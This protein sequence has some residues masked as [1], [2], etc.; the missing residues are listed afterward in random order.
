MKRII[1]LLMV[2]LILASCQIFPESRNNAIG[3][4]AIELSIDDATP[5][6]ISV[7]YENGEG[8]SSTA[9]F[10]L[11][12]KSRDPDIYTTEKINVETGNYSLTQCLVLDANDS[13]IAAAP[14]AGSDM[15]TEV[16]ATLPLDFSIVKD[17]ETT[18]EP[19]IK[20]Y[21][22]SDTPEQYGYTSATAS[23]IGLYDDFGESINNFSFDILREVSEEHPEN[24]FISPVSLV[25]AFG[26]LHP[27]CGDAAAQEIKDVFYLNDLT[28][29]DEEL[30]QLF[31]DFGNYLHTLD[32]GVDLSLAHAFW[33]D[34]NKTPSS[35]YLTTINTY[36]GAET[37]QIDFSNTSN[38]VE[39]INS[40]AADKTH[41][42]IE[43][44]VTEDDVYG[45]IAALANAT[46]FKGSWVNGFDSRDTREQTF[47]TV[48]DSSE[49]VTCDMMSGGSIDDPWGMKTYRTEDF[50]L[51]RIP[52]K[53][54]S[55]YEMACLMPFDK[56]C[57]EFLGNLDGED[58]DY[59]MDN[60]HSTELI[61]NMP[62]F[63]EEHKYYLP[64]A[65]KNLGMQAV[66]SLGSLSRMFTDPNGF[67]VDDVIQSTFIS[68]DEEGAEA[69][70][71][72]VIGVYESCEPMVTEITFDRPFI[73]AIQD[74]ETHAIIFIGIMKEPT[75]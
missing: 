20:T 26:L 19:E 34:I 68:V 41:D 12:L 57:E 50:Q 38:V 25:Y 40:W 48:F 10:N 9:L 23:V 28:E 66:F 1:F 62:K 36:F 61:L 58:W 16:I 5:T 21:S 14:I 43:E 56:T 35:Q 65:L 18:I 74:A 69:A 22:V 72:T 8:E 60:S 73:Y 2:L 51:V 67:G 53:D 75:Q 37:D 47:Y 29:N 3:S 33:Y 27:G 49:T 13:I 46:Y 31:M 32:E 44:V 59:W 63:E 17:E 30:Y 7:I 45:W 39:E 64:D 55:R 6:N 70:A 54:K 52:F 71:V 4:F 24:V 15:A 11:D 42:K